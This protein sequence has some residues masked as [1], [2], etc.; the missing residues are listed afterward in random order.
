MTRA[1]RKDEHIDI[2]CTCPDGPA[3]TGFEDVH[4]VHQAVPELDLEQIDLGRVLLSKSLRFPLLI[5][6]MTGGTERAVDINRV[7]ALMAREF[8][9]AMAVGSQSIALS[10]SDRRSSFKVVRKVNP[11]GLV[12]ANISALA[13]PEEA[14]RAVEMI[15]A[16]ALQLH[17]NVPQ[18]LAMREGERHFVGMLDNI[19]N[20]ASGSPVPIIAKEVGFGLSK[21]SARRLFEAGVRMFDTGGQGGTNFIVIEDQRQGCFNRELDHWGMP[22]AVSL[23]ELLSLGLPIE[24]IASGGIR[25]ALDA[26]KAISL[27]AGLVGMA[28]PLL[29]LYLTQGEAALSLYLEQWIYRLKAVFLMTASGNLTSL[30]Q[31]PVIILGNTQAWLQAR[32]IDCRL[33]SR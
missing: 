3:K 25:T 10:E 31:K 28:G 16:D 27:G 4:L 18:E 23:A 32:H 26:A 5:N 22:T 33:W 24:V 12:F 19:S 30:R 7:M 9:L 20:I 11:Q 6:A 14:W 2:T 29:K 21:E 8:G 13:S 1:A 15:E 17:L